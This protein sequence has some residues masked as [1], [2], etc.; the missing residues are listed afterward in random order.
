ML[1]FLRRQRQ[2]RSYDYTC[3]VC[4]KTE[5]TP[6]AEYIGVMVALHYGCFGD[7]LENIHRANKADMDAR[8]RWAP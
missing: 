7:G 1:K 5:S 3:L 2:H 6:Y 4:H 8:R